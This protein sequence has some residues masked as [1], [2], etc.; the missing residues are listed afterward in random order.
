MSGL[1][2]GDD[3]FA[4]NYVNLLCDNQQNASG[5]SG[6]STGSRRSA[7]VDVALAPQGLQIVTQVS[8]RTLLLWTLA[9]RT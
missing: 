9:S 7:L 1:K 5:G 2:S 6:S 3:E 8:P 4:E